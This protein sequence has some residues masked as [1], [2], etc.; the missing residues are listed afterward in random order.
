MNHLV[1]IDMQ[2]DFAPSDEVTA[3][4]V[5]KIN[6]AIAN[7]EP[8]YLTMDTHD[9]ETYRK[10]RESKYYSLHCAEDSEGHYLVKP[11]GEAIA[12]YKRKY[13]FEKETFG[14]VELV[15]YLE[16]SAVPDDTIELCGVCTDIC[17]IS[18]VLMFRALFPFNRIIVD[19]AACQGSTPELHRAALEIMKKNA[20]EVRE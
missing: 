3:K 17:V 20:I 9:P 13:I 15:G 18:N 5:S 2:N 10:Y 14:S 6:R 8:I 12:L 19:A 7:N 16:G 4:V 11:V 1:V